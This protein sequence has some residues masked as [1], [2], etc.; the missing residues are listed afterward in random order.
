MVLFSILGFRFILILTTLF[1]Q[2]CNW[3][4]KVSLASVRTFDYIIPTSSV[5]LSLFL[6][7]TFIGPLRDV[8]VTPV[9]RVERRRYASAAR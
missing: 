7:W 3:V 2:S 5:L 6:S 9:L 4:D 1:T 8:G